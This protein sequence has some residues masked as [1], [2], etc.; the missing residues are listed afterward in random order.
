[1]FASKSSIFFGDIEMVYYPIKTSE[2][3][4]EY[5]YIPTWELTAKDKGSEYAKVYINAVD[6]SIAGY[7]VK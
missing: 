2:S 7:Q 6:G 3:Q 5:T 4:D 1:M